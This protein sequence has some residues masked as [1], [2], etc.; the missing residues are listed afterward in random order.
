MLKT[1]SKQAKSNVM[2]YIRQDV[3]YLEKYQKYEKTDFDLSN[4][5]HVCS[6]IWNIFVEEKKYELEM[7]RFAVY[8]VFKEWA[9]G[10]ALGQLF[11]YYYNRSAVDDLA[12]IL[13]ENE[14]EKSKYSEEEA[15][16]MLTKLIFRVINE[17]KQK[18]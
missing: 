17:K 6:F 18:A 3:D 9:Q 14:T 2:Q 7:K 16:E 12:N 4:D 10:L 13:E 1:N 8:E 5:N 15:E 11:C